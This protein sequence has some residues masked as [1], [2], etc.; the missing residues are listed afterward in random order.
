MKYILLLLALASCG[1]FPVT[2]EERLTDSL[3]LQT[4][5]LVTQAQHTNRQMDYI[6]KMS[7]AF[8]AWNKTGDS[9]FYKLALRY[10]DTSGMH[11]EEADRANAHIQRIGNFL[12]PEK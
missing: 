11:H 6:L 7:D 10:S 8:D 2:E 3:I 12:S 5:M 9:S 4:K 1:D